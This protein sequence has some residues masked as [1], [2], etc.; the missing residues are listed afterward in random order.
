MPKWEAW[1]AGRLQNSPISEA[2]VSAA[3]ARKDEDE[4]PVDFT[5]LSDFELKEWVH[6]FA[7][8]R[9]WI[10]LGRS[11][12]ER[13]AAWEE[14]QRRREKRWEEKRR[15]GEE[16]GKWKADRA[17]QRHWEEL[18]KKEVTLRRRF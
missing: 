7:L 9:G 15:R 16:S 11:C 4:E 17:M 12:E 2:A 8:G 18:Q 5:T 1:F 3:L 6:W 13:K 14:W 10:V